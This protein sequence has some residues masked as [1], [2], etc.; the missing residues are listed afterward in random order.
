TSEFEQEHIPGAMLVPLSMLDAD[1]FPRITIK[2]LVLH[3]AIGKRSAAAAKQL[4]KAGHVPPINMAGGLKAWTE[5]GLETEIFDLPPALPEQKPVMVSD[6]IKPSDVHPGTVLL[7]EFIKPLALTQEELS[8][9][10]GLPLSHVAAIVDGER[11]IDADTAFRLARYFS[12]S[13]EF[14]LHLQMAYDLEQ[15][16]RRSGDEIARTITPR[17]Y[18]GSTTALSI[19]L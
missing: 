1:T 15:A 8:S 11:S 18:K 3:C 19:A 2:K 12:T 6:C 16:K 13:E 17:K 7:D 10:I 4:I 14:W 5:A 9:D